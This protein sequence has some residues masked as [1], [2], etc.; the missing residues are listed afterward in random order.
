M[1]AWFAAKFEGGRHAERVEKIKE[2]EKSCGQ[3]QDQDQ[4]QEQQA[5]AGN[6]GR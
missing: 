4:G 6:S 5:E 3:D 1:K 2:I